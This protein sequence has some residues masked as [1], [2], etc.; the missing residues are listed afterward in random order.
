MRRTRLIF[1][2]RGF[3]VILIF[4][5]NYLCFGHISSRLFPASFCYS[6]ILQRCVTLVYE[7]MMRR[8]CT[9]HE[10]KETI[11]RGWNSRSI[12]N[13]HREIIS[14]RNR[15]LRLSYASRMYCVTHMKIP[16]SLDKGQEKIR[17]PKKIPSVL[18]LVLHP[19]CIRRRFYPPFP[20]IGRINRLLLHEASAITAKCLIH[21]NQSRNVAS[22][23]LD[24]SRDKHALRLMVLQDTHVSV[25]LLNNN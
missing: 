16:S 6:F 8:I 23:F 2:Q 20:Y 15:I 14:F 18:E 13:L 1:V 12:V 17:P 19:S 25:H 11:A 24:N 5:R 9:P 4:L 22:R 10:R 7:K 3:L 21:S